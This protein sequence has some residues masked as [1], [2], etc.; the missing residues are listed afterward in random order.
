MHVC[1]QPTG[2]SAQQ[3]CQATWEVIGGLR[4][5]A[6]S[7]GTEVPDWTATG[8][9]SQ[10]SQTGSPG[11]LWPR[12]IPFG[13]LEIW[14]DLMLKCRLLDFKYHKAIAHSPVLTV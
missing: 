3:T 4:G 10:R 2:H 8:Q 1:S 6:E 12:L 11:Y 7:G 13:V 9:V 5:R 14:T